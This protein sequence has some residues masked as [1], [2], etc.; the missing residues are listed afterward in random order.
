M[1]AAFYGR[2]VQLI[3]KPGKG[4]LEEARIPQTPPLWLSEADIAHYVEVFQRTGFRGGLN[5]YRNL[6]RN[7][8]LTAPWQDAKIAQP[9]LFIAGSRDGVIT[10]PIGETRLKEMETIV[11]DLRGKIILE[12][13][14]HWI[15]QERAEEVNKALLAFLRGL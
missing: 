15:Q 6:D 12:G 4:L 1:R 3:M 9:S 5:W 13:A 8:A 7:W 14:G 2:G 10:G 11:S